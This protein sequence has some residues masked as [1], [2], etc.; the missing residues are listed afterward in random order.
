MPLTAN[1]ANANEMHWAHAA[2]SCRKTNRSRNAVPTGK[3]LRGLPRGLRVRLTQE[4]LD[5]PRG[6]ERSS[7]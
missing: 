1:F 2:H 7:L 5:E 6:A 4:I 3:I